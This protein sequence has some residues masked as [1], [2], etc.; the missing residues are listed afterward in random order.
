MLEKELVDRALSLAQ[1]DKTSEVCEGSWFSFGVSHL[2]AA[3][4]T[5]KNRLAGPHEKG[6]SGI[7]SD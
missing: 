4:E 2:Q 1:N 5:V 3:A 6:F 7:F